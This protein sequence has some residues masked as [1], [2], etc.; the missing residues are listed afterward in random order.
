MFDYRTDYSGPLLQSH[1][2]ADRV[3]PFELGKRLFEAANEP[4]M[5]LELSGAGH[6]DWL[7]DQYVA[8]F[9]DFI[10]RLA[11]KPSRVDDQVIH[12]PEATANEDR[13]ATPADNDEQPGSPF[14]LLS[15]LS[16]FVLFGT[17]LIVVRRRRQR[18]RISAVESHP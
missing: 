8:T 1:G 10:G 4:K 11:P 2:T 17:L 14:L 12:E 3:I 7:T 16:V 9:H 6:D 13:L 18:R 15:V 5:F